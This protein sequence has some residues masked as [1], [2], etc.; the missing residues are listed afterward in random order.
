M[1]K[2]YSAQSIFIIYE[3]KDHKFI[4]W[5]KAFWLLKSAHPIVLIKVEKILSYE[6]DPLNWL[7]NTL[8]TSFL[9]PGLYVPLKLKPLLDIDLIADTNQTNRFGLTRHNLPVICLIDLNCSNF[10]KVDIVDI[11]EDFTCN[12]IDHLIDEEVIFMKE[13]LLMGMN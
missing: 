10:E 1:F 7:K 5:A 4:K 9:K 13:K 11:F 3:E 8:E 12:T 6:T 2:E